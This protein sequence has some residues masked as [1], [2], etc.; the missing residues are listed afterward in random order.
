MSEEK[1]VEQTADNNSFA[2]EDIDTIEVSDA[3]I[4]EFDDN[5]GDT[6]DD[7]ST[8]LK[9]EL[10][11]VQDSYL[12]LS[13]EFDN[14]RKRTVREKMDLLQNAGESLLKDIL[15]FVDDFERGIALA[16]KTDDANA[17]KEGMIL[18]HNKLKDFLYN[19]GVKE[20][21]AINEKFDTDWHEAITNI[22]APSP[23][24]KGKVVDVIQAGYTINE[25]VIRYSKVVVG[26]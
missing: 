10:Q 23:D 24:L 13:A 7:N 26:E 14:Y 21:K 12:R 18:I 22:P 2:E 5:Q 8:N 6:Q 15:P 25:K 17:V 19:N 3:H 9:A 16:S 20:I 11:R 4:S 1:I